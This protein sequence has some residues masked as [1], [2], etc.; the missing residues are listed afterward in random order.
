M[1][2][3]HIASLAGDFVSL[4]EGFRPAD[5]LHVAAS[6]DGLQAGDA[7]PILGYRVLL[8]K[9]RRV[10]SV[11]AY[12]PG[13]Q[14]PAIEREHLRFPDPLSREVLFTAML[15]VRLSELEVD[16]YAEA[17]RLE[18]AEAGRMVQMVVLKAA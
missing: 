8:T 18:R 17:L 13:R 1:L 2:L 14:T 3:P 16:V 4:A 11:T 7:H 12:V 9:H 15:P 10:M 6:V 5:V